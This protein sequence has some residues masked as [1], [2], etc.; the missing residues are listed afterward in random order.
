MEV[1]ELAAKETA[2]PAQV[3]QT[4]VPLHEAQDGGSAPQ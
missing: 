2:L 4:P 1:T 3:M